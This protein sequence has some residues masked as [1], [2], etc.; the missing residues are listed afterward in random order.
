MAT[1]RAKRRG[2]CSGL[3]RESR[4]FA[5]LRACPELEGFLE[6]KEQILRFAQDDR[7]ESEG[8][9]GKRARG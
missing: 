1:A 4:S 2:I 3:K 8:M 6:P 7:E 9:T 5:A